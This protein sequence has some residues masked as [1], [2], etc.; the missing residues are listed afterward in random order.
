MKKTVLKASDEQKVVIIGGSNLDFVGKPTNKFISKTS[1]PGLADISIG[2]V[3]R[4]VFE[5]VQRLGL[6]SSEFISFIGD[7]S[8]GKLI[9]SDFEA[10]KLVNLNG[11]YGY[12]INGLG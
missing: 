5:C 4:N 1:N 7:D 10:K 12:L 9:L 3:G 8:A 6:K 11:I 2:G